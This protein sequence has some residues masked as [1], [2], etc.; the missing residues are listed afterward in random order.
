MNP[1]HV[2]V[3][4]I[5]N[6]VF[7]SDDR[8]YWGANDGPRAHAFAERANANLIVPSYRVFRLVADEPSMGLS[9]ASKG[10]WGMGPQCPTC[11]GTRSHQFDCPEVDPA[12][13]HIRNTLLRDV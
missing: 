9:G 12:R 4:T 8:G 6:T 1:S 7:C 11:H 13:E 3:D 10:G 5:L 2:V